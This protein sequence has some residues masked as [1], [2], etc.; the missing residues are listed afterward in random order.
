MARF[1][2]R[3]LLAAVAFLALSGGCTSHASAKN[4]P[5]AGCAGPVAESAPAAPVAAVLPA[6]PVATTTRLWPFQRLF[7]VD[8]V[9]LQAVASRYGLKLVWVTPN[10]TVQLADSR[11]R[12]RMRFEDRKREFQF[13][14]VHVALG[15]PVALNKD[16]LLVS[17]ID[18]IKTI[19]PLMQPADY[20]EQLPRLPKRIFLD[21][22]HGGNDP[23]K[24]NLVLHIDEKVMTL[25]VV[26][27]LKKVL[28]ARG[29]QAFL[30]RSDDR[31]IELDNRPALANEANADLFVSVH[32][33]AADS[34]VVT[35]TETWVLTPQ[36]HAS[37]QPEQDKSMIRTAY[38][39]NHQDP[40][41]IVLGYEIHRILLRNLKSA[42]RGVKR[43]RW[44][45]L[46]GA[47]C[48]AVLIEAA[49]LSNNAEAKKIAT[50]EFR[51]QLAGAIADGIDSYADALA[52]LR[53]QAPAP[54]APANAKNSR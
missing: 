47:E 40:A 46:R 21:A 16:N 11:G 5:A 1:G 15:E 2:V 18:V 17:K 48:P 52:K 43:A 26:L 6:A 50:P 32:F 23:G 9:D 44:A 53:P 35:G 29:Y 27:R 24:Q 8:Y 10:K 49:F 41:N 7:N 37:T 39:G 3:S 30:T 22:G 31:R 28:E 20:V 19:A 14:G 54:A 34:L 51:Q 38:L 12:V 36:F 13:D 4:R 25:D 33:N 42:D 45:V